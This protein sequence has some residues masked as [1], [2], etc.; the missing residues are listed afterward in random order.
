LLG[1]AIACVVLCQATSGNAG[2]AHADIQIEDVAR[3]YS[4]YEAASGHPTAAQ[5]QRDY[6]DAGSEGLHRLGQLRRVTGESIAANIEKSPAIYADARKCMAVLPRVRVRA[7]AALAKLGELYPEAQ[8]MPVTIAVGRGKPVGVTDAKGV[9]IG[10]EALCAVTWMEPNVEDRFVHVLAH[11]YAH[12]QQ[13][14]AS[15][16]FY[17][18]EQPTV[19]E[20]SLIEGAAE[21]IG[22]MISG[23]IS[24]ADFKTRPKGREKEIET[25][26]VADEDRTD[27]SAWLYNG[28]L[29]KPGDMGYW[30][31][32]RIVKSYYEHASDKRQA[33][34]EIIGMRDAKA[35]LA[36]SG[37]TPGMTQ[38]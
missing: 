21:F 26:F 8:Y 5:L 3:F 13:A 4:I 29:T 31:G 7:A 2:P 34:R 33:L 35:F 24:Y 10:L 22:E 19:L 11:E 20:E 28:T 38:D 9:I 30:V 18:N 6:L 16:A 25:A 23:G 37:W 1:S 14:N 12:V 36:K 15:P 32:Y 17:D 27:L